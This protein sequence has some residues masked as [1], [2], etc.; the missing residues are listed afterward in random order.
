MSSIR[1]DFYL[2]EDDSDEAK[3]L[4][5]CRLAEKAY[6]GRH[7]LFIYCDCQDNA[8]ML[9]ELLWTYKDN[10]FIPH[11][12]QG[13]G[14]DTPPPIQIGYAGYTTEPTG[15]SDI[16]FNLSDTIPS[17]QQRFKRII[18]IVPNQEGAKEISRQHYRQYRANGYLLH[19]HD[20]SLSKIMG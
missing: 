14:P 15:F 20:I 9:D 17:F 10:S 16:L 3:W 2:L 18:E 12:L 6:L 13:E 7:Q 1:V 5:A 19:T 11:N 4:I 8:E